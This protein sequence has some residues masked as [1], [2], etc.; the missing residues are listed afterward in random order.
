MPFPAA[1][2]LHIDIDKYFLRFIPRSRVH[3]LPRPISH[4]LGHRDS[5]PSDI[6]NVLVAAWAFVGAFCGVSLIEAVFMS[7]II[8]AHGAPVIVASFV[9]PCPATRL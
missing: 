5:P 7:P 3:R 8:Q 9:R 1:R 6:G 2:D 4:F